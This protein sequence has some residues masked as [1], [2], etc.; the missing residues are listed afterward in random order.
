[1]EKQVLQASQPAER[2]GRRSTGVMLIVI[3]AAA[4]AF[5]IVPGI[6]MA[7]T[8]HPHGIPY[9]NPPL[10]QDFELPRADGGT[11]RLSDLRGQVVVIYFGYTSCPD[12]C[13]ATLY[14]L[15]RAMEQL[16][17]QA[18]EVQVVFI[19]IDPEVDTPEKIEEYLSYFD[20]SFIGLYGT[21]EQLQGVRDR[22]G[23][24]VFREDQGETIP[25]Y[26]I[27]HTTSMFVV[28]RD[29]TLR[30]RMH[31]STE[32]EYLVRDL[33]YVIQGRL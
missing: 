16:G 7:M 8:P 4:A 19:T 20:P 2:P 9:D 30:L 29:G 26:T 5:V 3:A 10:I 21:E 11:L 28:G 25:G 15:R 32:V 13:P 12:V 31:H 14:D 18:R 17:D 27:T 33:R 1:M 22:F 24:Q 6:L 23:V